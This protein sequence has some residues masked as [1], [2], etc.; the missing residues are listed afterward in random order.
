MA[1]IGAGWVDGAWVQASWVT[2]GLGAWAQGAGAPAAPTATVPSGVARPAY[3]RRLQIFGKRYWVRSLFE[4]RRLLERLYAEQEAKLLKKAD[5]KKAVA[6]SFRLKRV[7]TRL[8]KID[9]GEAYKELLKRWDE[10]ILFFM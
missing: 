10:E 2:A 8:R 4:E 5:G 7:K 9:E 1:S 6:K 3:P